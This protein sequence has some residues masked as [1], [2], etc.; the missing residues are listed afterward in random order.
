MGLAAAQRKAQ[1]ACAT[2]V[3]DKACSMSFYCARQLGAALCA[4]ASL[5][6]AAPLASAYELDDPA[7]HFMNSRNHNDENV[8]I[9]AVWR[10]G[11]V[12]YYLS[13]ESAEL[14]SAV[15][16]EYMQLVSEPTG[17]KLVSKNDTHGASVPAE[18]VDIKKQ[19]SGAI[20]IV[21]DPHVFEDL[22]NNHDKFD[23]I[24][25]SKSDVSGMLKKYADSNETASCISGVGSNSDGYAVLGYLLSDGHSVECIKQ[26]IY[27]LVGV[28]NIDRSVDGYMYLCAL[29]HARD[30]GVRELSEIINH[31]DRYL[32]GCAP[33]LKPKQ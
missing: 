24:G 2:L 13:G 12:V 15:I 6:V 23:S 22:K 28:Y 1:I 26:Q 10:D 7:R 4:L 9:S 18:I 11:I 33:T 29:Y 31:A 5:A 3:L 8:R 20:A 16:D 27:Q 19:F 32:D 25:F 21:I 17:L 30:K 14:H